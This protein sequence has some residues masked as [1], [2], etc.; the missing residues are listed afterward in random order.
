M[1]VGVF[2]SG[3]GVR[4]LVACIDA[5]LVPLREGE[6]QHLLDSGRVPALVAMALCPAA[7]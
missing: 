4:R 6:K 7:F 3:R 1:E 2:D 5:V